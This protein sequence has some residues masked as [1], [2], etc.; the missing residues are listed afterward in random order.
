[1]AVIA[2]LHDPLTILVA[3]DPAYVVTPNNDGTH[4]GTTC[5]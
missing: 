3:D 4:G 2:A 5:A 1:M